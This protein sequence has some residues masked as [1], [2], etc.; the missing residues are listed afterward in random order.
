MQLSDGRI[1]EVDSMRDMMQLIGSGREV[2]GHKLVVTCPVD[3]D[4]VKLYIDFSNGTSFNDQVTT[5]SLNSMDW[6]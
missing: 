6:R 2:S 1:L 4:V 5:A 3:T